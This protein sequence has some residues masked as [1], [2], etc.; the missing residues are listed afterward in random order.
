MKLLYYVLIAGLLFLSCKNNKN[1]NAEL[2]TDS[3]LNSFVSEE[4]NDIETELLSENE[5]FPDFFVDLK[6]YDF[7]YISNNN[8]YF[9]SVALDESLKFPFDKDILSCTFNNNEM[10]FVV[11]DDDEYTSLYEATFNKNET[12][13]EKLIDLDQQVDFFLTDTYSEKGRVKY[14]NNSILL[15]C[16]YTWEMFYFISTLVYNIKDKTLS[17]VDGNLISKDKYEWGT[18]YSVPEIEEDIKQD[19]IDG[20]PEIIYNDSIILT[21]GREYDFGEDF[22]NY[23]IIVL[24]NKSGII[25]D[26]IEVFG[27]LPHGPSYF[28][29]IDGKYNTILIDDALGC[30]N[31]EYLWFAEGQFLIVFDPV[32]YDEDEYNLRIL[33]TE[34]NLMN[35]IET[36]VDFVTL[37]EPIY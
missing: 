34:E 24:P 17:K 22:Y 33:N 23:S 37:I 2:V 13:I 19:S 7:A 25:Y 9:F 3:T 21:K 6:D 12:S 29:S 10:Y 32:V 15:E 1:N 27:D 26:Y 16:D 11:I 35:N 20:Y 4:I 8:L 30:N 31:N 28:S 36:N 5:D 14:K 18:K